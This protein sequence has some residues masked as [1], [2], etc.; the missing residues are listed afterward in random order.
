M[1][2]SNRGQPDTRLDALEPPARKLVEAAS[3]AGRPIPLDVTEALIDASPEEAL[4][5]GESLIEE[6]LLDSAGDSFVSAKAPGGSATLNSVRMAY[7]YGEL[8]RAFTAAGYARRVPALLGEYLLR[9]G[10]TQAAVVLIDAAASS[11]AE[12]GEAAAVIELI[13]AGVSAIEEE[14]V[15]S[16]ELEGRLRLE[17]AKYYQT[18]GWA[19]RAAEDLRAAVR[20]LEGAA[21][22]DAL[23]FLAAVEDNR[24]E[25]QTAEV[26]AAVAIGEASAIGEPIKAGSLSLLQ[27]RILSRIG[28]PTEADAALA[29]GVDILQEQGNPYQRFLAT[30]N[31]ARIALDRGKAVRAEPL[32]D[33]V[34]NTA[35]DVGGRAALADAAAWLARAQ[36]LHGHP[37]RGLES[38]TTAIELA[39][40]TTTPAPIFLAHMAHS[41]GAARFAAYE[42][43]LEAADAMLGYVLRQLP[44]WENAARYLRARALL[45]LGR[46][47]DAA[48]EVERARELTPEGINGWRWRLRIEA[49]RFNVLAAQGADW[50]K[51][52]AE[53]LTDELLQGQWLDVAAELMAV[54]AGVETDEELAGQAAALALRLG[55]PTTAASAIEAG[56]LWSDDAGSAVASRIKE[57]ARHVPEDWD[58]AWSAQPAIAA[59]LAAPEVQDEKLAAAATTLQADLDTALAAA[60]LADPD[61]ALS[62]AQ[63]RAQG[64]VRRRGGRI[65]RGAL[66][67]GA[68]AAVALLA[69]VLAVILLRPSLEDTKIS[70]P[71][72]FG[73]QWLTSGFNQAR[74]G[75]SDSSGV[76]EP[77]GYYWRNTESQSQFFA[78]PIVLGQK[79]VIGA[80]DGQ[81]YFLDRRKGDQL[82]LAANTR[83]RIDATAASA[84]S[85]PDVTQLLWIFITS[86]NGTIS[87]FDITD[88]SLVWERS[89]PSCC[90][91][92]VDGERL[93][94][95]GEDGLLHALG[96]AGEPLW[97]W[98][99]DEVGL[100]SRI[101]TDITLAGGIAYFA[102]GNDLWW[103]DVNSRQGGLCTVKNTGAFVTPVIS[104]GMIY[105]ASRGGSIH[106]LDA[107]SCTEVDG[108]GVFVGEA[109][110]VKPAVH[111]GIV[112]QPGTRG[113]TAYDP[114]AAPDDRLLWGPAP[115]VEGTVLAP[116]VRG[117]PVVAGG[118]VYFGAQ[119]GYV[120][121]LDRKSGELVWEWYEGVPIS[122]APTV[123]DG[124]VYIA[125]TAGQVIAIG[126]E[127]GIAE[128]LP[129]TT[130]TVGSRSPVPGGA[131]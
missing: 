110:T 8:A 14:G 120:Y 118:L 43:A 107:E 33:R 50:P 19:D 127:S 90:T 10:D 23:G 29:K 112:Y 98:P 37:G 54:R 124:V 66:L 115:V 24:Q 15:G 47:A 79:V 64:L 3:L 51:S 89:I 56:G 67:L 128:E 71:E 99:D 117:S 48:A 72:S 100:G 102:T 2:S 53:E 73:G 30:Q 81:V 6:G 22:V 13:E 68:A 40:A 93:F 49:F 116:P 91:P 7:L 20:V 77:T 111:D 108:V 109:L 36:F 4:T 130:S 82:S 113:V 78:S 86:A 12:R 101:N 125:T 38:V 74:T 11:A 21:R 96:I 76:L 85:T 105:A 69:A 25:P 129:T 27:A 9:A 52:R 39:E 88:A 84:K 70:L 126:G 131:G 41:E 31:M 28:F 32:F 65:G 95:G 94:V 103:L 26:Y 16:A 121:A 46:V 59:A 55:I 57:T 17:R 83:G 80:A 35:E 34:F 60:G 61:T 119:N 5:V 104:E 123:T 1:P 44:D 45:G 106:V 42:E 18:A 58:E 122:A 63:R 114:A 75:A 87:A 97:Y 62:P 92:A